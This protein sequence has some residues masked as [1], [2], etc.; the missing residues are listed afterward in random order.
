MY[1]SSIEIKKDLDIYKTSKFNSKNTFN[2]EL[3]FNDFVN[4]IPDSGNL[5]NE[6]LIILEPAFN[7]AIGNQSIE[8]LVGS[9]GADELYS[10]AVLFDSW[11]DENLTEEEAIRKLLYIADN[12]FVNSDCK[13][14]CKVWN[15]I[16]AAARWVWGNRKEIKEIATT[17]TSIAGV[18]FLFNK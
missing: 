17:I 18:I 13:F 1:Y 14:F 16:K 3:T 4:E 8:E 15:G 5:T 10:I 7:Y 11:E 6:A 12:N 9:F 2:S